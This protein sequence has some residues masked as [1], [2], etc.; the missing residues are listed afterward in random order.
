MFWPLD[1]SPE[2]AASTCNA[3]ERNDKEGDPLNT[4]PRQKARA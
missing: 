2:R 1:A 4:E 3:A